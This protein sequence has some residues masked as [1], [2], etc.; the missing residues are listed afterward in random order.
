MYSNS[1]DAKL[2]NERYYFTG[3]PCKYGHTS[4]RFTHNGNCYD[5]TQKASLK[6]YHSAKDDI[7][8]R[9]KQIL[10]KIRSR[11]IRQNVDFDL[12]VDDIHWPTHCPILGIELSYS[13]ADK[14]KGV[15]L[16]K[17]DPN[18]GYVKGNVFVMS[19]RANRAKWNL[20]L[21]EV[22]KLYEYLLSFTKP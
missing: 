10:S 22:K 1:K 18:K 7:G 6:S 16:D 19:M 12:T 8:R 17:H 15:S 3:I 5:C 11:A 21:D 9:K 20:T 4:K 13:F 2:N 14:D